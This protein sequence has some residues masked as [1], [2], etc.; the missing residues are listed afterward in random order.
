[1]QITQRTVAK[2]SDVNVIYSRHEPQ[3]VSKESGHEPVVT[4]YNIIKEELKDVED[5]KG[6]EK[7]VEM[8]I[9]T[10]APLDIFGDGPSTEVPV[11]HQPEKGGH[12]YSDPEAVH[13]NHPQEELEEGHERESE[14]QRQASGA[15][16]EPH[17]EEHEE[18]RVVSCEL[19]LGLLPV[20]KVPVHLFRGHK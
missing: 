7:G 9:K 1:M 17:P 16:D 18:R 4:D 5:E 8:D 19:V 6:R 10:V 12:Q 11:G 13:E 3:C 14:N 20:L 2:E 15:H